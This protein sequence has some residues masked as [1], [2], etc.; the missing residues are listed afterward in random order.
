MTGPLD[1]K[2]AVVTGGGSGIGR[3]VVERFVADGASV[4]LADLNEAA[5]DVATEIGGDVVFQRT[6]VSRAEQVTAAFATA[7]ARF[8]RCD[9]AVNNA[10]IVAGGQMHEDDAD[11]A[12]ER[13]WR[14]CV[15]GVWYGCR[16]AL[17]V[18]RPQGGGVILNTAST[19]AIWPT[20]AFPAYGLAKAAVVHLTRS[21]AI[22]YG[23]DAVRVNAVLPGPTRTGIFPDDIAGADSL[24]KHYESR[25][26]LARMIDPA[27]TAAAFAYLAS[28]NARSV[29]GAVLQVDGGYRPIYP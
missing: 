21:L 24:E 9:I 3:A 20:P 28:D 26:S 6:D 23:P 16:S 27:E 14:V 25:M 22:G 4:V 7:V 8:G 15:A 29:T 18:M 19:A 12:L 11:E 2:V 10:G 5:A 13:L 17:A 1:G